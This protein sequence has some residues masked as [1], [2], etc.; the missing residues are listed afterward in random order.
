MLRR[1]VV[2]ASM[3]LLAAVAAGFAANGARKQEFVVAAAQDPVPVVNYI[4]ASPR[5]FLMGAPIE[6]R[7]EL[8]MIGAAENFPRPDGEIEVTIGTRVIFSLSPETEGIWQEATYGTMETGLTV[9]QFK[10]AWASDCDACVGE[11]L[12]AE[13]VP[14]GTKPETGGSVEVAPCPWITIA[15]DGARDTRNGPSLGYVKVGVPVEFSEPGLYCVRGIVSTSVKSWSPLMLEA[16]QDRSTK[17]EAAA[18]EPV[19]TL[20]AI[21]TDVVLVKV[22]VLDRLAPGTKPQVPTTADPDATYLAPMPSTSNTKG[23]PAEPRG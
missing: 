18:A 19:T 5:A 14:P 6:G 11:G 2:V 8:A 16:S 4:I 20:L 7:S 22:R 1:E 15:T 23:D 13:P 3:I 12:G 9:Q 17:Q 10:A 21:D